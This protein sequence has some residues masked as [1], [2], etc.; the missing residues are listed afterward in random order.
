MTRRSW[1]GGTYDRVGLPQLEWGRIV[2]DRLP[3]EGDE[4]V[5][6]A[7]CGSGRVTELLLERLP[8]GRVIAVDGSP[9]MLEAAH[10]RLAGSDRVTF[11]E[12]DLLRLDL[13]DERADAILSTATFHWIHD[14]RVLFRRLHAVL[15]PG[16]RLVA[17]CGGRGN[18]DRVLG[19]AAAVM[20]A[21]PIVAHFADWRDPHRFAD[22]PE[23]ELLLDEAGFA[24]RHAWLEDAPVIPP[25]PAVFLGSVIL[26]AHCD[27]LPADLRE[28]F[29][30]AVLARL[31]DPMVADYVRL[32]IDAVA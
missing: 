7:G 13:G 30:A 32:N 21:E 9:S 31:D 12:Q 18:L 19:E 16:G 4:T 22:G 5:V 23:T 24:M 11:L 2:L 27:A 15:R 25:E 17:Q 14:H 26:G 1:D 8:R 3:L 6:D 29:V 10:A 28:P 20:A